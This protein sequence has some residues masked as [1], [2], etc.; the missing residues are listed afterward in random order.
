MLVEDDYA[1]YVSYQTVPGSIPDANYTVKHGGIATEFRVNQQMGG[2]TWVYLGTFHFTKG[3]SDDNC[4][5]LSNQSNYK[6]I[7]T[8][9]A[10][11]LGGGMGNIVRGDSTMAL[12]ISSD[13]PRCLEA[14][15]YSAQWYGMP[16]SVY[17][18]RGNDDGKDDVNT[19]PFAVN[20]VTRGSGYLRGDS[21]LCV[22]SNSTWPFTAMQA[23]STDNTLVGSLGIYT[24]GFYEGK[25][26]QDSQGSSAATSPIWS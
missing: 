3:K 6:G 22:P 8:A 19:R 18:R 10:V 15:R 17:S 9:D 26:A 11:R 20:H 12:P 4:I 1:V 2:G 5:I 24:T 23:S 14:A 16:D 13:L 21:G 7:V 25:T